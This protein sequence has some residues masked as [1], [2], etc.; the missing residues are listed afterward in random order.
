MTPAEFEKRVQQ[1]L[2]RRR[3]P[4]ADP[5]C[6]EFLADHPEAIG[7]TARLLD[8]CAVLSTVSPVQPR[9]RTWRRRWPWFVAIGAAAG[10][11]GFVVPWAG[12]R[13]ATVRRPVGRVLAA[14]LEPTLPR[15]N[16]ATTIRVRRELLGQPGAEL[17]VFTQW[18]A[19]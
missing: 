11:L 8:R 18:S 15:L 17:E 4:L 13:E 5:Q 1:L 16:V 7:F 12:A 10:V 3:D 2:D 9:P 6:T 19:R 14:S